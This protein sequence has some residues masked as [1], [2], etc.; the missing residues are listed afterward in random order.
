MTILL[1]IALSLAST[2]DYKFVSMPT[3]WTPQIVGLGCGPDDT[4][5]M[6]RAED[7]FFLNEAMREREFVALALSGP[8]TTNSVAS[9]SPVFA[10]GTPI[11]NSSHYLELGNSSTNLFSGAMTAVASGFITS[12]REI[13]LSP[14]PGYGG[15][16]MSLAMSHFATNL[17]ANGVP[18][19]S[20]RFWDWNVDTIFK[21]YSWGGYP[22]PMIV[23][24]V[25]TNMYHDL[26][27][28]A[29]VA[30]NNVNR[31]GPDVVRGTE[32][33]ENQ[34]ETYAA[35]YDTR[36]KTFNFYQNSQNERPISLNTPFAENAQIFSLGIYGYRRAAIGCR[37]GAV[38]S[39]V[40]GTRKYI[41]QSGYSGT[42]AITYSDPICG[43][44][45]TD[46]KAV[47]ISATMNA[48]ETSGRGVGH[49]ETTRDVTRR[50]IYP[51]AFSVGPRDR[52]GCPSVT[53]TID[54]DDMMNL[55]MS[56]FRERPKTPNELLAKCPAPDYPE[57]DPN[58][59]VFKYVDNYESYGIDIKADYVFAVVE[60]DFRAKELERNNQ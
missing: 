9:K 3:N 56:Q 39:R 41:Y 6:I 26:R 60:V 47:F 44:H 38:E 28:N 52:R 8:A 48:Y 36:D 55:A 14:L 31:T 4:S 21:R 35:G 42:F 20:H 46:V 5:A 43:S 27:A 49:S 7:V 59:P 32:T 13:A 54:A 19:S 23:R 37:D 15:H 51:V 25:C 34:Y 24:G 29:F 12:P 16:Y 50:L 18:P 11:P 30:F 2:N 22:F 17:Y 1:A 45:V 33:T 53:Y 58:N 57:Y 40:S 10:L